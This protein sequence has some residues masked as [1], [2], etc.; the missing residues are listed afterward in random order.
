MDRFGP[1]NM[2][3]EIGEGK[4]ISVMEHSVRCIFELLS[5]GTDPQQ[6]QMIQERRC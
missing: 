6:C 2:R 4:Q 5:K 3:I 1:E